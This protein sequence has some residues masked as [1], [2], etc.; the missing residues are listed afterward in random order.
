M[1][2]VDRDILELLRNEGGVKELVLTPRVISDNT[3]WSRDTIR[4]HLMI[5]REKGLVEYYDEP[6]AVHQLT[7]DGRGYINGEVP[8]EDFED[9]EE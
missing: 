6:G 5:L 3:D 9:D 2:P 8:P 4:E 7:D 1:T